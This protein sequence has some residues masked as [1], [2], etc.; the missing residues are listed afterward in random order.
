[1]YILGRTLAQG[2]M[3]GALSVLGIGTGGLVHTVFA[4]AGLSAI[5][6]ASATAFTVVKLVGAAYLVYLGL[7]ALFRKQEP[8]KED[9][10]VAKD[11]VVYG[12]AVVTQVLNPKLA[13]FMISFLPQFID[14]RTGGPIS[15][16][17]LGTLFVVLDT[18]WYLTMVAA[19]ARATTAIRSNPR[20]MGIIQRTS[21]AVY[22]ALGLHLLSAKRQAG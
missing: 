13:V 15:F 14:S 16:L 22:V 20:T 1:M 12:Q 2:R 3:A 8:V 18:V 21:G 19:A 11:G 17:F 6:A 7:T 9:A 5:L 4:A 10:P